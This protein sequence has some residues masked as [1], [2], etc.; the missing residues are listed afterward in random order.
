M[1]VLEVGLFNRD[2]GTDPTAGAAADAEGDSFPNTGYE[3]LIFN[4]ADSGATRTVTIESTVEV[5]GQDVADL[6]V[7]VPIEGSVI[8]G[9]F[10][11]GWYSDS[12]GEV[13]MTYDDE[14]DLTV[15]VLKYASA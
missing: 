1:A 10:P 9:P 7:T 15:Q 4:N 12:G 3:I 2:P 14:T 5:D 13:N 8:V 11:V 6:E